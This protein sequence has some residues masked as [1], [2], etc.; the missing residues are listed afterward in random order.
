[1]DVAAPRDPRDNEGMENLLPFEDIRR[2]WP[3][4][5]LGLEKVQEKCP[6]V[7]WRCEDV[8]AACVNEDAVLCYEEGNFIILKDYIDAYSAAKV[9]YVWIAYGEGINAMQPRLDA[10][11][12]ANDYQELRLTS[13]RPGWHNVTGWR[14]MESTFRKEL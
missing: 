14:F 4:V 3:E 13:S 9:L 10:F 1:M 11:A 5:R 7:R 6:E 12:R 2:V 8:Y